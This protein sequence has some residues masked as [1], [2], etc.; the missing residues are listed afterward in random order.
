MVPC[1]LVDPFATKR[2]IARA[3]SNSRIYEY[4]QD[5]L[6][7][8][9]HYF[10]LPRRANGESLI[11]ADALKKMVDK[12]RK[13]EMR[14]ENQIDNVSAD[15]S[16]E[17]CEK[18]THDEKQINTPEKDDKCNTTTEDLSVEPASDN[19]TVTSR[20]PSVDDGT[21]ESEERIKESEDSVNE[22]DDTA[23]STPDISKPAQDQ[24]AATASISKLSLVDES[25]DRH[26]LRQ[27]A[28]GFAE[29]II[30]DAVDEISEQDSPKDVSDFGKDSPRDG[31]MSDV[32]DVSAVSSMIKNEECCYEFTEKNLTD[33]KV[34][35]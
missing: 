28:K 6:R 13:E 27:F 19:H 7:K 14:K 30:H 5:T 10:G 2:N 3:V 31:P 21:E 17:D 4:F 34:R 24:A 9:Y 29:R 20:T 22:S 23:H 35:S 33:G 1:F 18:T 16:D 11:P 15:E 32:L 25:S 26:N 8:A 12:A